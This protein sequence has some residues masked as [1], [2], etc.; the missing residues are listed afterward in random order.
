M[1]KIYISKNLQV[2]FRRLQIL[3]QIHVNYELLISH[4]ATLSMVSHMFSGRVDAE[5][6]SM[7]FNEAVEQIYFNLLLPLIINMVTVLRNGANIGSN[8]R[9]L[10]FKKVRWARL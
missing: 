10:A 3:Q 7:S 5:G 4:H 9:L 8:I 1:P 6:W 2:P